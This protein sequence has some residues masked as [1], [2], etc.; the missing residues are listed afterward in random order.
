MANAK[1]YVKPE[2]TVSQ[3]VHGTTSGYSTNWAGYVVQGSS[4]K[5]G[6]S[7]PLYTNVSAN[8]VQKAYTGGADP[9]F[10][11]GLDGYTGSGD[12]VQAGADSNAS[13]IGG[14]SRY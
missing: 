8:W 2:Q 10:R 13:S 6:T 3:A 11:V 5:S 7:T 1:H 14:S 4:N 12:V 9:S